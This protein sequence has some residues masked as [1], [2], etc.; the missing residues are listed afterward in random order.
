M[1]T[2]HN[3]S[4]GAARAN[5]SSQARGAQ[6]W[7]ELN[8]PSGENIVTRSG[9][10]AAPRAKAP[11]AAS[12][13]GSRKKK[14]PSDPPTRPPTKDA[15][16]IDWLRGLPGHAKKAI[17]A[18]LLL[19]L[20]ALLAVSLFLRTQAGPLAVLGTAMYGLF[21]WGTYLLVI[22]LTALAIANL[23]EAVMRR[24]LI[25]WG[26]V[27]QLALL[28]CLLILESR[29]LF[30]EIT[31][32]AFAA[33]LNEMVVSLPIAAQQGVVLGVMALLLI[34]IFQ[35]TWSQAFGA[36]RWF[37]G[38]I[39]GGCVQ[40]ARSLSG[41]VSAAAE[42]RRQAQAEE[43]A[44]AEEEEDE[45]VS[46]PE[47]EDLLPDA[48]PASAG[49]KPFPRLRWRKGRP[50]TSDNA[51]AADVE[52][53][54][55]P[56]LP[57]LPMKPPRPAGRSSGSLP[58]VGAT[59]TPRYELPALTLLNG[60]VEQRQARQ[61]D[62]IEEL[63]SKVERTLRSFRVDALVRRS[64]IS[65]GPTVIRIGIRPVEKVK[66]DYRG[67]VVVDEAGEP[68]LTRTRVSRILALQND[69]ALDLEAKTIRMEAP[70]PGRPYVGVEIP[71][72]QGRLVTLREILASK[73]YEESRRASK[74][75]IALGRD[76]TGRARVGDIAR[77]PHL[78]I[79]GTTGA[80]KSVCI[81]SIIACLL[82]QATPEEVRFLMVDP[83]R[84][85]LTGFNGIPH[86]LA[87]V[88]TE[89]EKVVGV[90]KR[91]VDEMD[92][93]YRLFSRLGVR[94]L[95]AYRKLC[96]LRPELETLPSII[97]IID[98]LADLMATA[99]EETEH[100]IC[101]LAQLARATGIHLVVATQRPSVDVI[102]GLIKANFPTRISF[103]VSSAIDSRTILDSGGAE[104]LLGRGDMLYL[105]VDASKP[106]RIQ[107]TF[108][109]DEELERIVNHWQQTPS[110]TSQTTPP[111]AGDEEDAEPEDD[112]LA[113]A[114]QIVR[115]VGKA[116]TSLLQQKL[117]VG[118]ARA[119][120]LIDQL[121]ARGII[122]P[123]QPA[124]RPR[125]VLPDQTAPTSSEARAGMAG[126]RSATMLPDT[127]SLQRL[128]SGM[129][130]PPAGSQSP[131]W[132][133]TQPDK[134]NSGI[135]HARGG[136]GAMDEDIE[137]LD[138]E[139]GQ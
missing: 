138:W 32:G 56:E 87:P 26:L 84:V 10:K 42:R 70:V 131:G 101:R 25:R 83:K 79:A 21:G 113:E 85:E 2:K 89:V 67:H 20:T 95:E 86:L 81:N 45:P 125:E 66:R 38:G 135:R 35:I 40:L 134:H 34:L 76:V 121:E 39:I 30:G 49:H 18:G 124:G 103:M 63:A 129:P 64:D 137:E 91:G 1:T 99:P 65:I 74:L 15:V 127:T 3:A 123:A 51:D 11:K 6:G 23:S 100:L 119:A 75:S 97:I 106:E 105:P 90:L 117:R 31:G 94:N 37:F 58:T 62:I 55:V 28:V 53:E 9:K 118:Y 46:G 82:M 16:F 110:S 60:V 72:K 54:A 108:L 41:S 19:L 71:N 120:R 68:V 36:I 48:Q 109:A 57:P 133:S 116:S 114:A 52:D 130:L 43:E 17:F 139:E 4:R 92:R 78:L 73:E 128:A 50:G 115:L 7:R 93:R 96:E 33:L 126:G 47:E 12:A 44:L 22:G 102:T 107:G 8:N 61:E 132:S 77:F 59:P 5:S 13:G 98:E 14:P 122:G 104:R 112:L 24:T 111:W 88:V 27:L 29:L 136:F 80:G 69:L